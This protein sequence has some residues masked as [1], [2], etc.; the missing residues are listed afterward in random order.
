MQHNADDSCSSDGCPHSGSKLTFSCQIQKYAVLVSVCLLRE[1]T[2]ENAGLQQHAQ[3][4]YQYL[5]SWFTCGLA[6]TEHVIDC[7]SGLDGS[8]ALLFYRVTWAA[9]AAVT[10][11]GSQIW[12]YKLWKGLKK[13]SAKHKADVMQRPKST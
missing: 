12:S 9:L 8:H 1:C 3:P 2:C 5:T 13:Q 6:A 11:A 10:T 7:L 4:D